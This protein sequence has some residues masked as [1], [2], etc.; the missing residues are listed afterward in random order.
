MLASRRR[1]TGGVKRGNTLSAA[2]NSRLVEAA[3]IDQVVVAA[4]DGAQAEGRP[5]MLG[6]KR[7]RSLAGGIALGDLDLI[8]NEVEIAPDELDA[9]PPVGLAYGRQG[10]QRRRSGGTAMTGWVGAENTCSVTPWSSW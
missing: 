1:N 9:R 4:V 8:E 10:R 3:E 6:R 2:P 7:R 5:R